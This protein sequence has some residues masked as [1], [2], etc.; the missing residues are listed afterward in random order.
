MSEELTFLF[1]LPSSNPA[2]LF[3]TISTNPLFYVQIRIEKEK[4]TFSFINSFIYPALRITLKSFLVIYKDLPYGIF[5]P[6]KFVVI[7]I[8]Y[9]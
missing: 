5:V 9:K 2:N 8:Q 7:V 1:S 4:L 6:C 3:L